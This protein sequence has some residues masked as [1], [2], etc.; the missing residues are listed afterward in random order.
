MPTEWVSDRKTEREGGFLSRLERLIGCHKKKLYHIVL[1]SLFISSG[2]LCSCQMHAIIWQLSDL[3]ECDKNPF[4]ILWDKL[5]KIQA[6]SVLKSS[7]RLCAY[8]SL[9]LIH[10][11][12]KN[13]KKNKTK[14]LLFL[15]ISI[16]I[17]EH[18][19]CQ[20]TLGL[21]VSLTTVSKQP[22][23]LKAFLQPRLSPQPL[24]LFASLPSSQE[25]SRL[26][27]PD[28]YCTSI[29]SWKL[30]DVISC[31]WLWPILASLDLLKPGWSRERAVFIVICAI[32]FFGG[33]S[34]LKCVFGVKRIAGE[35]NPSSS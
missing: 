14:Y 28:S 16:N 19:R 13:K 11:L 18:L 33:S 24:C 17:Q 35:L 1:I 7:P 29:T 3:F 15:K 8:S 5:Y 20:R 9:S 25:S 27:N 12:G 2:L 26:S 31:N 32:I 34:Q 4:P 23:L 22:L 21:I 10:L 6:V 30:S